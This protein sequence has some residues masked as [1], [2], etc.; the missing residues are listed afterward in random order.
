MKNLEKIKDLVEITS[1][2]DISKK[3]RKKHN[4]ISRQIYYKLCKELTN[5]SLEDIGLNINRDHAT[6]IN[7]L[8]NF[9]LDVKDNYLTIYNNLFIIL[10]EKLKSNRNVNDDTLMLD[11]LAQLEGEKI[12][13]NL[14]SIL[15]DDEQ[16]L[17]DIWRSLNDNSKE[18]TMFKIESAIKIQKTMQPEPCTNPHCVD[19]F[20]GELYGE[21]LYCRTCKH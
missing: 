18:Y 8:N 16:K 3:N 20:V 9:K 1:N 15:S 5:S 21:K 14:A 10:K 6:V 13:N 2:I 4:V 19:G 7:G 12:K 17:I 11:L